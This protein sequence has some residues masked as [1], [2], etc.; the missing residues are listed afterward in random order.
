MIIHL[1]LI[2]IVKKLPHYYLTHNC[3]YIIFFYPL[4]G[5]YYMP[6]NFLPYKLRA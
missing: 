1:L 4:A 3:A 5:F 2:R 6:W